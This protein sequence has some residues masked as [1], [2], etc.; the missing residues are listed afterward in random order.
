MAVLTEFLQKENSSGRD[1]TPHGMW[2]LAIWNYTAAQRLRKRVRLAPQ[3][4]LTVFSFSVWGLPGCA[5]QA[6]D[7]LLVMLDLCRMFVPFWYQIIQGCMQLFLLIKCV[8]LSL[9]IYFF[10]LFS[11]GILNCFSGARFSIPP[12]FLSCAHYCHWGYRAGENKK[13]I[14][15]IEVRVMLWTNI[16]SDFFFSFFTS[17]K[18]LSCH[19]AHFRARPLGCLPPSRARSELLLRCVAMSDQVG[20]SA[21]R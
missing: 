2:C 12:V 6:N 4:W 19:L 14:S 9:G 7:E 13:L 17:R 10:S 15:R 11:K 16:Y 8:L 18:Q 5:A 21:I 20:L 1:G 3:A